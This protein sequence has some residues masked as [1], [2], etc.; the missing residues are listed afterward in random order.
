[1]PT[2]DDLQLLRWHA[3]DQTIPYDTTHAIPQYW[4]QHP[5]LGSPLAHETTLDDGT[6]AQAFANGVVQ[7]TSDNG[8]S[9][10]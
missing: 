8:A 10:V 9:V 4:L 2:I 5:E 3:I 7:W 6:I 1:M